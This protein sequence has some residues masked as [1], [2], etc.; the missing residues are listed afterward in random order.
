[1]QCE[2]LESGGEKAAAGVWLES[3]GGT[4][5]AG[6]RRCGRLEAD[7][8]RDVVEPTRGGGVERGLWGGGFGKVHH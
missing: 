2:K 5:V 4:T 6:R 3:V 8:G 1:M 7:S